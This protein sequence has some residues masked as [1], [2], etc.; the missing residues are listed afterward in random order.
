MSKFVLVHGAWTG[1]SVWS[2]LRQELERK[3]HTAWSPTLPGLA[4]RSDCDLTA[5]TLDT[6]VADIVDLLIRYDL[7]GVTLVGHSYGGL[8]ITM[9]AD[10]EVSRISHLVYLDGLVPAHG[11]S[12]NSLRRHP[13]AVDGVVPPPSVASFPVGRWPR[14]LAMTGLSLQPALSFDQPVRLQRPIESRPFSRTLICATRR[15]LGRASRRARE[16]ARSDPRWNYVAVDGGHD[17][18]VTNVEDVAAILEEVASGGPR[19]DRSK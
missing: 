19:S 8:V 12:A 1:G 2:P 15:Q 18:M 5:V 7:R 4:E 11:E 10:Q 13:I 3:G 9:V 14:L 16:T 6:H 17:L